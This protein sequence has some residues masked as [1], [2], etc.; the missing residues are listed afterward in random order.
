LGLPVGWL[1]PPSTDWLLT[2]GVEIP[3]SL[4]ENY[5]SS[6]IDLAECPRI[7]DRRPGKGLST[8]ENADFWISPTGS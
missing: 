8:P 6:Q 5:G 1:W 4:S 3:S 2:I 7:N